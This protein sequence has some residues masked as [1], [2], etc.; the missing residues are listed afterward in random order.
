MGKTTIILLLLALSCT[1]NADSKSSVTNNDTVARKA[2]IKDEN[3]FKTC[4]EFITALVKSSNAAAF[5]HFN[6]AL[7]YARIDNM[8]ADKAIIKLYVNDRS[9]RSGKERAAENPVGWLAFHW[10][11]GQLMDITNDPGNPVHLRYDRSILPGTDLSKWCSSAAPVTTPG[12]DNVPGDVMITD[13]IRFNGQLK[14]FFSLSD[15]GKVFGKADSIKLMTEEA[16][17]SYIFENP[18]GSKDADDRYLY[19]NGSR[20]ENNK[21]QVAVDEF[22]FTNGN[23]ITYKGRKID[24]NT[25]LQEIQQLFP[26]AISGRMN[27]G[28]EGKLW[29]IQLKEDNEGVSDGHIKIFFKNGKVYY[30]HWWFP[31]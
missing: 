25:P 2:V 7:V 8:A 31:C 26:T 28:K 12:T 17:C 11:T 10:K 16:P 21:Q 15:F 9:D 14:R 22:W 5:K 20:F 27:L 1:D 24:G 23:Y 4:E 30:M 3:T 6:A 18:D 19:K 13:D 29:V